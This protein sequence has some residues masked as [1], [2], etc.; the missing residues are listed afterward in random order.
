MGFFKKR[1]N[2]FPTPY[3]VTAAVKEGGME[4]KLSML[5]MGLGN[6][7]HTSVYPKAI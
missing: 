6:M 3:T 7:M 5:I 2:E 1:V 4:T